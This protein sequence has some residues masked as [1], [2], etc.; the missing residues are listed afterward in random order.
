MPE[1]GNRCSN[2]ADTCL[3]RVLEVLIILEEHGIID[4]DLRSGNAQIQHS[5]IHRATRA[6]LAE[7]LLHVRVKRPEF[8]RLVNASLDWLAVVEEVRAGRG[9]RGRATQEFQRAVGLSARGEG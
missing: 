9:R 8:E 1:S 7:T 4:H 3:E 2:L 5:L 6:Q